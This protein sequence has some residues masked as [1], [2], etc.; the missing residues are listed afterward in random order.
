MSQAQ[1]ENG[2]GKSGQ[3]L[4]KEGKKQQPIPRKIKIKSVLKDLL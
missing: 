4:R 3:K 1:T 2:W